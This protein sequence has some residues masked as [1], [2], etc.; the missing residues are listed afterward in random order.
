MKVAILGG[1][2]N[3]FHI[4]HAMVGETMIKEYGYDKVLYIPT[5]IPPHK[6]IAGG[7][8][9]EHRL[10]MI[11]VFCNSYKEGFFEA[12]DCEIKRGGISYTVDTLEY[13]T[14]KYSGIIEGKP[15][16]L[17][18][19]EMAAEFHKWYRVERIV[20]LADLVIVPRF[21]D[22]MNKDGQGFHNRPS[23][24]YK[25]DFNTEFDEDKFG[26]KCTVLMEPMLPLSSTN[27]RGRIGENRSFRYLVPAPVFEYICE[28][29]LYRNN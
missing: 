8:S 20:E 2:F 19:S 18:G 25:G 12:E 17:M 1:S 23:G 14:Q 3:P 28:N 10:N 5:Y 11:K 24:L 21:P 16:L 22:L 26:F 6:E 27:I 7:I 29:G 9:A 13:I 15:A 4:G